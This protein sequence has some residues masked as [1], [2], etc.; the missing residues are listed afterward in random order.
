MSDDVAIIKGYDPQIMARLLSFLKPYRMA[1]FTAVATLILSTVAE[2]ALPV[3]LQRS[4]DRH[5]VV[6]NYRFDLDAAAESDLAAELI[7]EEPAVIGNSVFVGEEK[8]ENLTQNEREDLRTA[9]IYDGTAWYAFPTEGRYEELRE[10]LQQKARLFSVGESYAAIRL[11]DLELLSS[12][13]RRVM[14]LHDIDGLVRYS[15]IFLALLSGVLVFSFL[16]VYVT[17]YT[18]QS[19]MKDLRLKLFRHTMRQ[20]LGYIQK[21]PVG[22]LVT[23]VTNDVETINELFANVATSLL[24]DVT[25]IIGVVIT[26]FALNARLALIAVATIPPIIVATAF[27]R[28]K[29]REA[30]RRLRGWV[31]SVNAFLSEHVSGMSV[32]QMMAREV[33]TMKE[34]VDRN[35][36]LL[37]ANLAEMYVMAVFRPLVDLFTSVSIGVV[38]YFGAGMHTREALSLGILIAFVNL[39][40]RFYK[41]IQDIS[42]KFT[43]LQSAMAGG[44]RVFDLLDTHDEV[45]ETATRRVPGEVRGEISLQDVV[46]SYVEDE[47]V[48]NG[49][50]FHVEPGENV[51]IVGYTGAGKTTVINLLARLWDIQGGVISIDGRSI[52]EYPL[53]QLRTVVQPVQQ[54]VF[55]FSGSIADNLRLGRAI[56]DADMIRAAT[57]VNA[58]EFISRLSHGY[59]TNV[60]EGGANLSTGQRQLLSFAR[61]IAHDPRIIM[62]DEATSSVDTETEQLVQRA[63]EVLLDGR[64]SLVIAHRLSTIK[65]ADRIL[66]LSHGTLAEQGTHEELLAREGLYHSLYRLQYASSAAGG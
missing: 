33:R 15:W 34:F 1:V 54:D 52:R 47:P 5:I 44:E 18:G 49:L 19:V 6:K 8:L 17:A 24:K 38:I 4:I 60:Q 50:S 37:K 3:V 31:S 29:A 53:D 55:L 9:G 63:L 13:E 56:S 14:R 16:Q 28:V 36:K 51:A 39:I 23:R 12:D 27:F 58:H 2:L 42:E 11:A 25:I 26:L 59:D 43:I 10:L 66:V 61:V 64:T 35:T 62:L 45:P 7:A 20:S 57:A 22:G 65:N 48:L 40:G 21:N 32:V 46:F 41:P 30:Y